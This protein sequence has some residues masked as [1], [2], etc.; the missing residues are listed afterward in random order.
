VTKTD[1]AELTE[2]IRPAGFFNQKAVYLK[3]VTAWYAKYSYKVP[4]VQKQ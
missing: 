1:I 2:I 4:I 3:S